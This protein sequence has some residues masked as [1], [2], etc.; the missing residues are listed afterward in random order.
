MPMSPDNKRNLL[1]GGATI[2]KNSPHISDWPLVQY[3][4]L[5]NILEKIYLQSVLQFEMNDWNL[6]QVKTVNS[7]YVFN[8]VT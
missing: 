3:V 8:N 4:Y 1:P 5:V 6:K 2:S 7:P